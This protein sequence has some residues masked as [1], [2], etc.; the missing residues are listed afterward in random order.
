MKKTLKRI[1]AFCLC[2]LM[3]FGM[4]FPANAIHI[5]DELKPIVKTLTFD[6]YISLKSKYTGIAKQILEQEELTKISVAS[7]SS[8]VYKQ[9]EYVKPYTPNTDYAACLGGLFKLEGY[10]NYYDIT[11]CTPFTNLAPGFSYASWSENYAETDNFSASSVTLLGSGKF[12][13]NG[14]F[15]VAGFTLINGSWV[16]QSHNMSEVVTVDMLKS[17]PS[18]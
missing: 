2:F 16:S 7:S 6:E 14:S 8:Y 5:S 1:T 18:V 9:V 10:G 3:I 11:E 12:I 15:G 4:S 13:Y 17:A